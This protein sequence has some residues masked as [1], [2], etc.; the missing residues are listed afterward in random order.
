MIKYYA[1][2]RQWAL[3]LPQYPTNLS[4]ILRLN[5]VHFVGSVFNK[6]YPAISNRLAES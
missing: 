5:Y 4:K 2:E 6:T 1:I 3:L